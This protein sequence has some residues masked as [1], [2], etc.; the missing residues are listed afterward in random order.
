MR[1]QER[2]IRVCPLQTGPGPGMWGVSSRYR[3]LSYH[4]GGVSAQTADSVCPDGYRE[5]ASVIFF[6]FYFVAL[7]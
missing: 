2:A 4:K 5:T 7:L 6:I 1:G 3:Y